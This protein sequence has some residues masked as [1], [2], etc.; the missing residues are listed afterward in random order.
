[1]A[2]QIGSKRHP[3]GLYV[4]FVTEMWERFG[5]Y[6]MVGIFLLYLIDPSGRQMDTRSAVDIVGSY[7]ALVYLSPFIGGMLADRFLGYLRSIFIGGTLM[8]LGYFGLAIQGPISIMYVSLLSIIIGNGFFKPNISTLLGIMYSKDDLKAKKDSAYNIFYMGINI[9]AFF[10]NFVAAFLRN[11]YGWGYAFAAAG[12]GMTLGLIWLASGLRHVRAS[13]IKKPVS[14]EDLPFSK[15]ILYVFVPA[16]AFAI[17]GWILPGNLFGTD[18]AD[19]FMFACVPIIIFY[20]SLWIRAKKEEKSSI[21]ALLVVYAVALVF[22]VIYN[23]N[24]TAQTIW[25][26][27]YTNRSVPTALEPIAERI[28]MLQILDTNPTDTIPELNEHFVSQLDSAGNVIM[29]TGVNPYFQNLPKDEWPAPDEKVKVI[30][31]EVF[32]SVNP[33]FIII[34]TPLIVGLFSWLARRKK[35]PTTPLKILLGV[36][37]SGLSMLVM[38]F[39]A[40]STNIYVDKTAAVWLVSSYAVFTVGEL[41]LSPIGLS[42][43]SK[44]SPPRLTA[45][46][47]GGWFLI[48][49]IGGKLA[50]T[51]A[52]SWDTFVDKRVF[53][54]IMFIAASIVSVGML[55][56]LKWLNRIVKEH[57]A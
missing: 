22:W 17:I 54:L 16:I 40:W 13:D 47:M 1:M 12:V 19:A 46:M 2:D 32:Q 25:A 9:G 34:F 5:Y 50:G 30:S 44:V 23:Q 24:S 42:L 27:T 48:T 39:A 45:L 37:F 14:K 55:F 18:S 11:H 21:A 7:I 56:I 38:V 26:D 15:V 51:L 10:C 36:F 33:F 20:I 31:P 29:T 53:F 4:L 41:F 3:R 43:I 35:E 49:S 28:G 52:S 57:G 8:A 6:L